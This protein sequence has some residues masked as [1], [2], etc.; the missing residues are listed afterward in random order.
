MV[1][2]ESNQRTEV[3]Q[4]IN[5][6]QLHNG[7]GIFAANLNFGLNIITISALHPGTIFHSIGIIPMIANGES[8]V[9]LAR[10]L[11][12]YPNEEGSE[13]L[14]HVVEYYPNYAGVIGSL[15]TYDPSESAF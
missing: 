15:S 14:F 7:T 8:I 3:E 1:Q 4:V 10:I 12:T 2:N 13:H 11:I 9:S 5:S 6:P